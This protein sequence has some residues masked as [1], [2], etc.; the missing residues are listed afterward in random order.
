MAKKYDI[1]ARL[2]SK[3]E[4][5]FIKVK[6]GLTIEVDNSKTTALHFMAVEK[7]EELNELEKVDKMIEIAVGKKNFK[8]IEKLDLTLPALHLLMEAITAAL[9]GE[10]LE[11]A[12][13]RFPE[14][15][16]KH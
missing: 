9:G 15:K 4:R 3:N 8:E 11:E 12:K 13:E 6:E 16:N 2:A 5:P 7:D 14:D 1:V 10:D